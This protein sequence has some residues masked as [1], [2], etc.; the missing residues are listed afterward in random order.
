M[1]YFHSA[2]ALCCIKA[3]GGLAEHA[4]SAGVKGGKIVAFI[5]DPVL[6]P[7]QGL[8]PG[9]GTAAEGVAADDEGNIYGAEVG[10]RS[11]RRIRKVGRHSNL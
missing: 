5:P 11:L 3:C 10:A 1:T 8:E 4:V 7:R 9:S 2:V 6:T